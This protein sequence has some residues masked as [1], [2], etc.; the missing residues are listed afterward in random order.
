M[1]KDFAKQ[2]YSSS[3]WQACRNEYIE[4]KHHLCENCLR[5]GIYTPGDIVHHKIEITPINIDNPEITL[6]HAN[7]ELLCR[8]CHLEKHDH[9]Y[10]KWSKINKLRKEQRDQRRR[11]TIGKNGE[12]IGKDIPSLYGN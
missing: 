2:F 5:K 12:I 8:Q 4:K 6:N 10:S 11:F 9:H 3:R 1:A 7:L